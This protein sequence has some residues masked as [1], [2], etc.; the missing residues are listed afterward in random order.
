MNAYAKK[1]K[2]NYINR[3]IT[4]IQTKMEGKIN[5]FQY[6]IFL[7]PSQLYISGQC[8]PAVTHFIYI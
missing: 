7:L 3:K 8:D 1:K 2:K 6:R 4:L 5:R